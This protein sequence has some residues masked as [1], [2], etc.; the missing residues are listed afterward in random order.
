MNSREC[1]IYS[2]LEMFM[3]KKRQTHQLSQPSVKSEQHHS[4][5]MLKL[6]QHSPYYYLLVKI[7][8]YVN[9][10]GTYHQGS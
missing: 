5:M 8:N 10:L 3:A 4:R 1:A 9:W 6:F 7:F 2:H